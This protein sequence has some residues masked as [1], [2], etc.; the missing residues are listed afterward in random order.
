M[1]ARGIRNNN[2]LNIKKTSDIWLGLPPNQTDNTF[3][4]FSAPVY[5]I[6]AATKILINY[7]KR[8]NIQ[9]IQQII[10][11]WAPPSENVTNTYV[12]FVAAS[13]GIPKNIPIVFNVGMLVKIIKAMIVFENGESPYPHSIIVEGVKAGLSNTQIITPI[14]EIKKSFF[15]KL[16]E[17]VKKV[18]GF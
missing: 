5:G 6:R 18:F 14:T 2:P 3:F 15:E 7:N 10:N 17:Y 9:S 12:D 8:Y 16:W 4:T 1:T 13:V 11:R